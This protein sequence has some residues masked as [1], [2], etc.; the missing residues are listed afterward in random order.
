MHRSRLNFTRPETNSLTPHSSR[1][2]LL[3]CRVS[4]HGLPTPTI[5]SHCQG[6]N[7]TTSH[8]RI[9]RTISR[10]SQPSKIGLSLIRRRRAFSHH[11]S[12]IY[13]DSRLQTSTAHDITRS[14]PPAHPQ[15]Y[16]GHSK[17]TKSPAPC[18]LTGDRL[19]PAFPPSYWYNLRGSC[20]S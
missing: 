5:A 15:P 9:N 10:G 16:A 1:N 20:M 13:C 6:L 2:N 3:K 12:S 18:T 17:L 7:S 8:R 11:P 4:L 19:C 14:E